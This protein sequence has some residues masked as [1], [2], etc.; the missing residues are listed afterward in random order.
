MKHT[1]QNQ[2]P[3][4]PNFI[5]KYNKSPW[6]TSHYTD[7]VHFTATVTVN[8]SAHTLINRTSAWM[9]SPHPKR[10]QLSTTTPDWRTSPSQCIELG[11]NVSE[12]V[13]I[14]AAHSPPLKRHE[15][16]HQQLEPF[17]FTV[18]KKKKK[19]TIITP[20]Q[21]VCNALPWAKF[22]QLISKVPLHQ[23][24]TWHMFAVI[25]SIGQRVSFHSTRGCIG[26]PKRLLLLLIHL[27]LLSVAQSAAR[28]PPSASNC[29][30]PWLR[31]SPEA[32]ETAANQRLANVMSA[33][34]SQ[35]E[36]AAALAARHWLNWALH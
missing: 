15:P 29:Q 2:S 31:L 24:L 10:N 13:E 14:S 9:S 8:G 16:Q 35:S 22:W 36:R 3:Q 25:I 17:S 33:A 20:K 12:T 7:Q 28:A 32:S 23:T 27:L 30:S 18:T 5:L 19:G 4:K 1:E 26:S 34:L 21:T 11:W 6:S